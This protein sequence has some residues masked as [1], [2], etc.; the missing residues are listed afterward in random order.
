[1]EEEM[2]MTNEQ[3][4]GMLLDELEDWQEVLVF[5]EE[6]GNKKIIAKAQKQIK[7]INEKLKF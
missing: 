4:K 5:A 2:G 3:Y 6:S 7:K 1:M